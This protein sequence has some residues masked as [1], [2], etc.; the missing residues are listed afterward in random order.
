VTASVGGLIV[1]RLQAGA[2]IGLSRGS[3]G[4]SGVGNAANSYFANAIIN[5]ALGRNLSMGASWTDYRADIGPNVI[6]PN[7]VL[8]HGDRQTFRVFLSFWEPLF[9]RVRPPDAAR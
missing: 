2:S 1:R 8:R 6:V 7:G 3:V 9:M 4:F 5:Y